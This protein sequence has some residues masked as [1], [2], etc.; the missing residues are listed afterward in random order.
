MGR[1]GWEGERRG[2][3]GRE[4]KWREGAERE[5]GIDLTWIFVLGPPSS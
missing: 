5:R 3:K 4:G 2:G 1:D